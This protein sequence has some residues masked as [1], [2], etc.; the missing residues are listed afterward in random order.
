MLNGNFGLQLGYGVE[1]ERDG[2][3]NDEEYGDDC[4]YLKLFFN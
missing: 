3:E 4:D 2:G 1:S